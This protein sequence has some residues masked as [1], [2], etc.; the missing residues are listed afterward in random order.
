MRNLSKMWFFLSAVVVVVTFTGFA[1]AV[2]YSYK[3]LEVPGAKSTEAY[4]IYGNNIVGYYLDASGIARGFLYNGSAYTTLM[5]PGSKSTGANGIY[6][7]NIVGNSSGFYGFLYNGSTYT[8]IEA[9]GAGDTR[10]TGIY[11]TNI[12]GYYQDGNGIWH[13][14][15]YNGSTYSSFDKIDATTGT[16]V[17]GIYGN[18]IVGYYEAASGKRYGFLGYPTPIM[19]PKTTLPTRPLP[20]IR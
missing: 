9:P 2:E 5:V 13:G 7:N 18:N 10:A 17:N 3:T 19:I 11:G 14:Y 6:G 1:H 8:K 15:L 12:V 20:T 16:F 4:G